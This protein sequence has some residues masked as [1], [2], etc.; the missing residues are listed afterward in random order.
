MDNQEPKPK[1][2]PSPHRD[3]SLRW[4]GHRAPRWWEAFC[5]R[6]VQEKKSKN[7]IILNLIDKFMDN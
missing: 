2:K 3:F 1:T 5:I 6:A 4:K 7:E